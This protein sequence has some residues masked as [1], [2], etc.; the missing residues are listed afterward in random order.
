MEF[1]GKSTDNIL[2]KIGKKSTS[3]IGL[4]RPS[5]ISNA[6]TSQASSSKSSAST[7]PL[8]Q[9]KLTS[10]FGPASSQ[11]SGGMIMRGAGPGVR[12]GNRFPVTAGVGPGSLG[13]RGKKASQKPMLPSVQGSPVK[14][15]AR[16]ADDTEM[17]EY[18]VLEGDITIPDVSMSENRDDMDIS[19]LEFTGASSSKAK[20]KARE[21]LATTASKRPVALSQSM[22]ALPTGSKPIVGLMGPP[23][24]PTS[25]SPPRRAGLRS[26][27][28]SYPSGSR[29]QAPPKF[30]PE[31]TFLEGCRIFVDVWM[32]D[33]QDTSALYIDIAKNMGARVCGSSG[34]QSS[35]S[36]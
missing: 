30:V 23:P 2:S 7:K 6:S 14:G 16:E 29:P 1:E 19:E 27:S 34:R 12:L 24:P 32:S 22:S 17:A 33:G 5:T 36:Y 25:T 20:G 21:S 18:H 35:H 11:K 28:S 26:S 10:I 4:G 3:G 9:K 15:G 8:T 13:S 31:A